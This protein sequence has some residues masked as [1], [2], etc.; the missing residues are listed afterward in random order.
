[1]RAH[2]YV[3]GNVSLD[4]ADLDRAGTVTAPFAAPAVTTTAACA[5]ARAVLATAGATPR[6]PIDAEY[7]APV[8]LEAC[9]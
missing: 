3:T 6:D 2:A 9:S 7:L 4:G 1:M 8:R 5:A